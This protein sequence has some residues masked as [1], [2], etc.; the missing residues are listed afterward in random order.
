M[1]AGSVDRDAG[2]RVASKGASFRREE[3]QA[4]NVE[5]AAQPS[6]DGSWTPDCACRAT[7]L[8]IGSV[9]RS[10]LSWGAPLRSMRQV[11]IDLRHLPL[12]T[13]FGPLLRDV[14]DAHADAHS[15][16]MRT[17]Q[18]RLSMRTGRQ[19]RS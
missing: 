5:P 13:F 18:E 16:P 4:D 6:Q 2:V 1:V 11:E 10:P 17:P 7:E 15:M 9:R 8:S 12:Q 3:G 19:R 14:A